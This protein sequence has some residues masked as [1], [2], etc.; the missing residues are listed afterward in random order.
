[1][2]Y[3][4]FLALCLFLYMNLF[5][6]I[7]WVK[8]RNDVADVAW[9]LGFVFIAWLSF[10]I[11]GYY[12][13]ENILIS[14][15][16][17][18]WGAR[19]SLH[20]YLRNRNKPEDFR[21]Q[22]WRNEWGKWFYL[23]SYLQVFL[24]QGLFL[25]IISLPVLFI[26]LYNYGEENSALFFLGILVW[27]IGFLFESVSDWQLANFIKNP[28]NKGKIMKTG[29][30]K[31][32]RHPNYFGEVTQWW[33]L[34]VVALGVGAGSFVSILGPIL[35]TFLILKVSGVPLLEEKMK[36]NP[37]FE[38]YKKNTSIFFPLPVT[39]KK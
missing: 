39:N 17:T 9:G 16:V 34:F 32:S 2:I 22:K 11:S 7:S 21:Y 30:W 13:W 4:T 33:G 18:I 20:I 5:F 31:Y 3:F 1:M 12:V 24:L 19:L 37:E 10:Y 26:N 15:L 29:L 8:K 35:I 38:E 23:R 27:F 6:V 28:E 25:F 14:T 36:Q